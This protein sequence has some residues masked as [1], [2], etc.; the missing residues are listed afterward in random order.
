MTLIKFYSQADIES[1]FGRYVF[2]GGSPTSKLISELGARGMHVG[3]LVYILDQ[4]KL[5]NLLLDL[6]PYGK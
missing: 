2:G 6:K 1:K 3:E 4:L 5:E